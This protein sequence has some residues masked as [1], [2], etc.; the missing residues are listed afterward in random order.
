M[1]KCIDYLKSPRSDVLL[2]VLVLVL[3]NLVGHRAFVRA[4]LTAPKSYSLSPASAQVV[5]TLEQPLSVK[6]FFTE[7]LPAPYNQV[8]Q[9]VR[10]LLVEYKAK[11]NDNFSYEFFNM[12]DQ[13]NERLAANYGLNR[14]QVQRFDTNEASFTQAWMGLVF[15]YED[16]IEVL[17]RLTDT[18]GLEYQIT[19]TISKMIA[20]TSTLAGLQGDVRLTLYASAALAKFNIAGFNELDDA[21]SEA[22]KAVNKKNRGKISYER[23]DPPAREVQALIQQYGL[24]GLNWQDPQT[25]AGTGALGRVLS[26]G[27]SF[28]LVPL[29]MVR[30]LFGGN[31]IAGIDMLEESIEES[32]KSL[33]AKTL[34]I[35][36]ITGHGTKALDDEQNGA[37]RLATLVSDRYSFTELN[38]A[39]DDIPAG[40]ASIVVAG[41]TETFS[42][43]ELYK[44]DQFLLKGGNLLLF[45]DPFE[46][47]LPEG[48]MAYYQQPTYT[49]I[50]S[51]LERLLEANGVTLGKNYVLDENCYV[52][53]SQYTDNGKMPVYFAPMLQQQWLDNKNPITRN[54]GYVYFWQNGSIDVTDAQT[55]DGIKTTVLA[56][57]SPQSWCMTD[58]IMLNPMYISVPTD[59]DT[60]HSE[61][62]AVLLE[63]RFKSAFSAAPVADDEAGADSADVAIT[64]HLAESVQTGKLF[65][66]GSSAL[67][68]GQLLIETNGG[69]WPTALFVRNVI[70]YMNGEEEWCTMRTKGLSLNTLKIRGARSAT[71]AKYLNQYGLVALVV[72]VGF[73]VWQRR[74]SRR[75]KIRQRYNPDDSREITNATSA[76]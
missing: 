60:M 69:I 67:T 59:K 17:D 24:Q 42:D 52:Q 5:R 70:D 72:L 75:R 50:T 49:P 20:T 9:Y 31:A 63:G 51:G 14:V 39:D 34:Q 71:V 45:I 22:Y 11:A 6:V 13:A 4:D 8:E 73:I 19:T 61:N 46:E 41:A 68:T 55:A 56:R 58:N 10:D 53:Q 37:A 27:D 23:I 7:K 64:E 16:A 12:K 15:V 18:N 40:L 36:Y 30:T 25:G 38:L 48:Q 74:T 76:N 26:H 1:K 33:V 21:V 29:R 43:S 2:F 62:L 44:L 54:L 35:G 28:R 32:L 66:T 47:H 65:V 3:A 57:S